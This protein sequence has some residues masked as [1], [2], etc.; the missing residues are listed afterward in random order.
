MDTPT[1]RFSDE[2]SILASGIQVVTVN[3]T[4]Y[5]P[6]YKLNMNKLDMKKLNKLQL[7]W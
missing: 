2:S 3:L 6:L 1:V 5:V 4:L 7:D